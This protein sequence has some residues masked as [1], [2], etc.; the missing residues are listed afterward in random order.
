MNAVG[1]S[2]L[3][4]GAMVAAGACGSGPIE[5]SSA[6]DLISK[7]GTPT[8]WNM[9]CG[10]H[11]WDAASHSWKPITGFVRIDSWMYPSSEKTSLGESTKGTDVYVLVNG[12]VVKRD[13]IDKAIDSYPNSGFNPRQIGCGESESTVRLLPG[14]GAPTRTTDGKA[15]DD[16]VNFGTSHLKVNYHSTTN[17]VAGFLVTYSNGQLIGVSTL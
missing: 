16:A 14:F 4:A 7:R 9:T 1:R 17:G 10:R 11:A 2:V 13:H 15:P 5:A 12:E 6:S 8:V 3:L